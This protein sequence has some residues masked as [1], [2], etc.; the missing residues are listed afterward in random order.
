MIN[1]GIQV[2]IAEKKYL[3]VKCVLHRSQISLLQRNDPEVANGLFHAMYVRKVSIVAMIYTV[4][5][6]YILEN[7]PFLVKCVRKDLLSALH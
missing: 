2:Q 5:S 3:V 4:T 6:E 7:A 1:Q